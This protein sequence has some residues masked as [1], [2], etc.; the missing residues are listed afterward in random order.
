MQ[1]V[2]VDFF[3]AEVDLSWAAVL[4]GD[5]PGHLAARGTYYKYDKYDGGGTRHPS[6]GTPWR[7]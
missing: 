2:P 6:T 1:G 5:G 4:A 7:N 3:L